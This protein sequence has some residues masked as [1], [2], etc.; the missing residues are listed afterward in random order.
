MSAINLNSQS[1]RAARVRA[2]VLVGC[3]LGIGSSMAYA[4]PATDEV[5][6]IKVEY[7]AFDLAS[8]EGAHNLYRRIANAAQATTSTHLSAAMRASPRPLPGPSTTF[9]ARDLL[10]CTARARIMDDPVPLCGADGALGRMGSRKV[11]APIRPG[12]LLLTQ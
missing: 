3:A 9:A 8:D 6:A 12:R 4:A 2:L 7:S 1:M 10:R 11:R 5:P